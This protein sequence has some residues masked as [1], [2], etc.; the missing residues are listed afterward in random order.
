MR[1]AIRSLPILR[2][3][4]VTDPHLADQLLLPMA[5]APGSSSM[6]TTRVTEHLL[7]NRWVVEQF[8]PGRVRIEGNVGDPG[9]VIVD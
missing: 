3:G 2:G 4:E 9:L 6:T 8:L 7:T 5:L 1:P